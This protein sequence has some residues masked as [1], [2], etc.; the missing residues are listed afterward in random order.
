MN[1]KKIFE[2]AKKETLNVRL[3]KHDDYLR[4]NVINNLTNQENIGIEL[5]VAKGIFSKRMLESSKFKKFYAVDS[6][7]D[8]YNDD[9]YIKTLKFLEFQNSN[10]CLIRSDFESALNL[11]ENEYFDF[12]YIDGYAHTGE[13]GGKTIIEWYT[14]LKPGGILAG[15]DYHNDWPLVV[16][17]VNNIAIQL[18]VNLN[19]TGKIENENYSK[20]P[21]W[22][23]K[24]PLNFKKLSLDKKLYKLAM[25][26][27]KRIH[28]SRNGFIGKLKKYLSKYLRIINII[29]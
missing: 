2:I 10:F 13:E 22:F 5:G 26:E 4:H 1:S 14:K 19:I 12:I 11:F 8:T 3:I 16:W 15:D 27:K 9:D 25:S 29:K 6:Y 20:Y 18:D 17:A 24:K 28:N 7:T 23:I 21:S